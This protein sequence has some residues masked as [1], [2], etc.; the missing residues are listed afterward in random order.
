MI[1]ALLIGADCSEAQPALSPSCPSHG[2]G[3]PQPHPHPH[4]PA[5]PHLEQ[6]EG[7]LL[8]GAF[9]EVREGPAHDEAQL[10]LRGAV[11]LALPQQRGQQLEAVLRQGRGG[12][13]PRAGGRGRSWLLGAPA[14]PR[15]LRGQRTG[16]RSGGSAQ[17]SAQGS[18]QGLACAMGCVVLGHRFSRWVT[19]L[20]A[21]AAAAADSA[22][23]EGGERWTPPPPPWE[24][25]HGR[26]AHHSIPTAPCS[27][28]P[29]L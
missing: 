28:K 23:G 27:M 10:A 18:T 17:G 12:E 2:V 24:G 13:Q 1:V 15:M 5:P 29:D 8:G 14:V 11:V 22:R 3:N 7:G 19:A 4:T 16:Q 21:S 20:P 26:T 9:L 6:V 25:A